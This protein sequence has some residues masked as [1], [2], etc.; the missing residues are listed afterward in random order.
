MAELPS[1][2]K[3]MFIDDNF[4]SSQFF[5]EKGGFLH[6]NFAE[7]LAEQHNGI[8][9]DGKPHLF[10]GKKYIGLDKNTIRKLT[11]NYIPSLK[12]NQN[13]EVLYKLEAL[14]SKNQQEQAPPYFIGVKNGIVDI[15]D[16]TLK[17]FHPNIHITNIINVEYEP[18]I[19]S[20]LVEK[21][22]SDLSNHD[23]EVEK[24]L[25]EMIG[26]GLYRDNFLQKAFFFFSPGGN[27]KST[28]FKLLHH[29]YGTDNTTALSFKDIQSR[30]KPASLQGTMVNIAD[31]IDPDFIKETGNYKTIVTGDKFNAERKGQDDFNFTPYVKL[32]FA[33]NELPQTSDRSRGF[34]R[35]M[36]LIP[37]LKKF[38]Q[39]GEKGDPM[40]IHKLKEP[41]HLKALLNLSLKGLSNILKEGRIQEPKISLEYKSQY[42]YDNDP[43]MQFIN[44]STDDKHR[45]LPAVEGRPTERT[46]AIYQSWC[47]KNGLLAVSKPKL[48][49][50]L[51]RIGYEAKEKWSR[52]YQK[53]I[54]FYAKDTTSN[55]YD[56]DG[57]KL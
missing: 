9:L 31:D 25:Y 21:F 42:E 29:F 11:L 20:E 45:T 49:R 33:G 44:E 40:I 8:M 1:D 50:E 13:K 26:Y 14:C 15:R 56:F 34:Y 41:K 6:Y 3:A 10:D 12:E 23:N 35:R 32:M 19:K 51:R 5:T 30:F 22:I 24:L 47:N 39:D 52:E 28:L 43:I 48:T 37:M 46:Y 54:R 7:Y 55:Y 16:M 38:G 27:G 18:N 17:P 53:T 57:S 2:I 4:D 36:V